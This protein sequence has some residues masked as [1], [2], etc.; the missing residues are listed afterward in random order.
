MKDGRTFHELEEYNRG[1]AENP[2]TY[3]EIRAKFEE[4]AS[5]FLEPARREQLG[6]Q[7]G[8]LDLLED[9][10]VLVSLACPR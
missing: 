1:S 10:S 2:M 6:R 3:E 8:R 7:I 4:N 9:A 5:G